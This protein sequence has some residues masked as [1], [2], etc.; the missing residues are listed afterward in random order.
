MFSVKFETGNA[1]FDDDPAW[2]CCEILQRIRA[3]LAAGEVSGG[4][5]DSNGNKIGTWELVAE[6][7]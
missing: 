3:R 2:E 6:R 5:M 7:D 1:A 4:I